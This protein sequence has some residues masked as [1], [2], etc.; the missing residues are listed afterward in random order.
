M[1]PVGP[2]GP[3]YETVPQPMP[4]PQKHLQPQPLFAALFTPQLF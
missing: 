2:V 1:G 4:Q 3:T